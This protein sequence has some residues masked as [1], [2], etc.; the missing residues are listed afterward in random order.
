LLSRPAL[1]G[2]VRELVLARG[3]VTIAT[4]RVARGLI[5]DRRRVTGVHVQDRDPGGS[6]RELSA[7]LVIDASGRGSQLPRWLAQLGAPVPREDC[8]RADVVYTSCYL[9]RKPRHLGGD[10]GYIVTPTP[11]ARRGA[12]VLALEGDRFIVTLSGYLGEPGPSDYAGMVA[13]ARTLPSLDLYR[14]LCDAEPLSEPVQMRDPESRWRRYDRLSGFPEGLLVCGDAL[15]SF[16]PAYAQGM[17]VAALEARALSACLA[18]DDP[19][20]LA[21]RYFRA[22]RDI[23]A[24]PWAI[25][26]V[27]DFAFEGVTGA[28]PF[29]SALLN[30]YV[31]RL[32]RAASRD[33]KVAL[34]RLQVTHLL[35][36]PSTLLRPA[37]VARVLRFGG[38]ST[39][40]LRAIAIP[41]P[42]HDA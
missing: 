41:H 34:A 24:A 31:A 40:D 2:Y 17:T 1:E 30:A 11:P 29:G 14:L 10:Y 9:R 27:A 38:A 36:A 4:G 39:R 5:G 3:N 26:V 22:A 15:C 33:A 32:N 21:A 20:R 19:R 6:A 35:A 8:V 23:V 7:E 28:R 18:R 13:Y 42:N 37:L 16:N 25:A 12:A